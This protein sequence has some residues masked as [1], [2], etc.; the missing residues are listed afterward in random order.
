MN[1]IKPSRPGP[2]EDAIGID[3]GWMRATWGN[4]SS[5]LLLSSH[6]SSLSRILQLLFAMGDV[7]VPP[8]ITAEVTQILSN[9]VLGDN[10][11]RTRQVSRS[12]SIPS[13]R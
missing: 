2:G 13:L 3:A 12:A 8:E 1:E 10:A 11:I 5:S 6:S 4:L 9:L 7:L